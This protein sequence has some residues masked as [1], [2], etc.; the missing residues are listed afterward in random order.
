MRAVWQFWERPF[1]WPA[2]QTPSGYD[3]PAR[4][5]RHDDHNDLGLSDGGSDPS[6]Y[7]RSDPRYRERRLS[8]RDRIIAR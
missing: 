3:R 5:W 6:R 4:R 2:A 8:Q 7:Y 1:S